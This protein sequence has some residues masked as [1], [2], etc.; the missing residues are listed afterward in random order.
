[1]ASFGCLA[2]AAVSEAKRLASC[3]SG[4]VNIVCIL[5][6]RDLYRSTRRLLYTRY[7][8]SPSPP[9]TQSQ[10]GSLRTQFPRLVCRC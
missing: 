10:L 1:M 2:E 3:V 9:L 4:V 5:T 6:L 7:I 8:V